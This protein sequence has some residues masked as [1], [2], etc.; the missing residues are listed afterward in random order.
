M[1]FVIVSTGSLARSGLRTVRAEILVVSA[2]AVALAVLLGGVALGFRLGQAAVTPD[3]SG[4]F[5]AGLMPD[6]ARPEN[7]ALID[8]V[9]SLSGRLIRLES[10]AIRL[11]RRVGLPQTTPESGAR[12]S[13]RVE[14]S[15]GPLVAPDVV[16][17]SIDQIMARDDFSASLR[18]IHRD[19]ARLEASLAD[20]AQ[21][22]SQA[23]LSSMAFPS[24]RPIPGS[25]ISSGFGNRIDPFTRRLAR[26][27]GLDMSAPFGT[28]ILASA[29]G[30]VRFAGRRSA[31]GRMVEIDHG[32][33]LATRY[34]HA[35]KLF[36][37]AGEVVLPGQKIAA[38]GSTGRSTGPH[39]HFEVLSKGIPVEPR[40]Y[41][42]RAGS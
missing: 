42:A 5:A 13:A 34:G 35:S 6:P 15:G 39:L 3:G 37:H 33:G 31:Y 32:N 18:R 21:A 28:P 17:V 11:A 4:A 23:D 27:T 19:L 38:V 26:H 25:R 41:L 1:A 36:V 8:R 29:G 40:R 9:G 30:R 14:P 20:V 10:E 16:P 22:T 12:D 24:R 7:R 2:G